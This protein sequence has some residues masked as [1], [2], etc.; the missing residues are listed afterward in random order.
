MACS[1]EQGAPPGDE[2]VPVGL[3][4]RIARLA[5]IVGKGEEL[6]LSSAPWLSALAFT[7]EKTVNS[8]EV[9]FQLFRVAMD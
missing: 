6:N 7:L 1:A 3:L 2:N 5:M 9:H 8:S 4:H